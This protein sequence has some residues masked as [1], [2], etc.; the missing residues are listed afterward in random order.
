MAMICIFMSLSIYLWLLSGF[1]LW[2]LFVLVGKVA[3]VCGGVLSCGGLCSSAL[4]SQYGFKFTCFRIFLFMLIFVG[5]GFYRRGGN[6]PR[7]VI[8]FVVQIWPFIT[9]IHN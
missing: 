4:F 3:L 6:A 8:N 1:L 7:H 9:T 5:Y 2:G